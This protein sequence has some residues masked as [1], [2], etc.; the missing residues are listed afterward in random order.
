MPY[1][2]KKYLVAWLRV[3]AAKL[4]RQATTLRL[5]D[6]IFCLFVFI[7]LKHGTQNEVDG[8]HQKIRWSWMCFALFFLS[9]SVLHR[10][11][12]YFSNLKEHTN[13]PIHCIEGKMCTLCKSK[14]NRKKQTQNHW[15]TLIISTVLGPTSMPIK[16]QQINFLKV[17]D[18]I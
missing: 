5:I 8:M 15:L 18:N 7:K 17:R 11:Y 3:H 9:M 12:I 2:V 6:T 10:P 4:K 16:K 14:T 1:A 13:N